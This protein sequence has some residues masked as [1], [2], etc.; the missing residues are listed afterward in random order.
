MRCND[1]INRK[2]NWKTLT[3]AESF[4]FQEGPGV[5]KWQF[6]KTGTK[7]INVSNITKEGVLDLDKTDRHLES[8]EVEQRYSH[9]L[10]DPGDFVIASSGISIDTDSLLR[11]RGVFVEK[12]HLPLCMNTS[13]IRFKSLEGISDL[14]Y[15]KYWLDSYEFRAQITRLVTGSAQKNFGPSHLKK[16]KIPLPPLA[17]QKRI[18]AILDKADMLRTKRRAALAKLD[19]LVQSVFLEMFGDPVTNPM[20]WETKLFEHTVAID[21]PMVDPRENQ[22][23]HLLHIGGDRIERDTGRILGAKTAEEDMLISGKFLFDDRYILYS[24]IRPNLRKVVM[25]DFRGLCS[26][27]V[28]PV[29]PLDN[30]IGREILFQILLSESFTRFTKQHSGRANIPKI[31]RKQFMSFECYIPPINLQNNFVDFVKCMGPTRLKSHESNYQ[32]DNLFH[33]LQQRAFRGEL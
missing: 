30:M 10:I 13:T 12:R 27:D 24:K 7:L 33:A 11:T 23:K 6:R 28:Y 3:L 9:F 2:D 1:L 20:G 5:R 16:I 18:A 14:R 4:W 31:N 17:E 32:S 21:A 15:L 29:R 26:A 25:P 8:S 22:Y 19:S